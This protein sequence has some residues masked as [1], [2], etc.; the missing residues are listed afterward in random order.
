MS[1]GASGRGVTPVSIPNTEVKPPCAYGTAGFP[2]GRV[3]RCRR[4]IVRLFI[5]MQSLF[6]EVVKL[7][8]APDSKSGESNL[9]GVRFPLSAPP[10]LKSIST[11][12]IQY[13]QP[14]HGL[15][16]GLLFKIFRGVAQSGSA[17][18]LGAGCREFESLHPD[19]SPTS[20]SVY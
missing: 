9:V 3:G 1:A 14:E 7:V 8:D 19:H 15:I 4:S 20:E 13:I 16:K 18:A 10:V 17:P 2:G 11:K 5:K 12:N 6:A